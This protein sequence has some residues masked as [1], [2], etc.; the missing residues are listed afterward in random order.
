MSTAMCYCSRRVPAALG[1]RS[2]KVYFAKTTRRLCF[3]FAHTLTFHSSCHKLSTFVPKVAIC[4][5]KF[6]KL[7]LSQGVL[8]QNWEEAVFLFCSYFNPFTQVAISFVPKVTKICNMLPQVFK[9]SALT[10]CT[11]S[12]LGGGSVFVLLPLSRVTA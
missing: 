2:H 5:H 7:T 11:L 8:Y 6:S 12:K 9:A 3:C 10:R 1:F 4:C